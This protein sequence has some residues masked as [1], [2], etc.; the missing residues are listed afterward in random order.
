LNKWIFDVEGDGL[1]ATKIHVLSYSNPEGTVKKSLRDYEEIKKFLSEASILIGH[2][3]TRWDIPTLERILG[4]KI[5]AKIVD[6]LAFSWI[7]YPTRIKHG[8]EEWGE[9]FGV[10]KPKIHDWFTLS[11]EEY[12][13]RCETD[14]EINRRLWNKQYQYLFDLY[15][16]EQKLWEYIDYISFKMY[17]ALLQEKSGWHVDLD[18][19][20]HSLQALNEEKELK[21]KELAEAMPP[22]PI[23]KERWRPVKFYTKDG[24]LSKLAMNWVALCTENGHD[25]LEF[26]GPV[27]TLI[28]YDDP[29]PNSVDQIKNWLFELGWKPQ[30]FKHVKSKA[31]GESRDVPQL[32][33]EHGKGICPSIK[34]LYEKQPRLEVLD[35]LSVL[36]HRIGVLRGIITSCRNG[37]TMAQI[38]GLTNTLRFQHTTVVNLPKVGKPY[39]DGIR[40][41]LIA[42]EGYILC[43]AD[44]ASLEDRIKQHFIY[45]HDPEYVDSMNKP[46]FDP[47]LTVAGLA[48]MLT[49]AEIKNYK[50]FEKKL[51]PIRDIAKNGNYACQYGAGIPRLM[52]TCG[53][54]RKAA[55]ALYDAYWKLNWAVKKVASEQVI[56]TVNQQMW[57]KNPI[58]GFYYS[59][60]NQKDVFSTLVQGTASYVFDIWV[61]YILEKRPQLTGQFHDEIILCIKEVFEKECEELVRTAIKKLNETIKLNREL[62]ISAQFGKNYGMIH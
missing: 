41:S 13:H 35:G 39:A 1:E 52:I 47:H 59:L 14:V 44:M 16:K 17:C 8:L 48:G 28:G 61:Q 30:T 22:V 53:I 46:D 34:K 20:T 27:R 32:N 7:L 4:I 23:Y 43:G 40:S 3:I 62:D 57:L 9:D 56:K 50:E 19:A 25:A 38:K 12:K 29:N 60:R 21:V 2:N 45:V 31:T 42:P 49:E 10:P 5:K 11:Y 24:G 26:E 6:T 51:K 58:N 37:K 54:D 36:S 15:G 55:T 18:R 33:L